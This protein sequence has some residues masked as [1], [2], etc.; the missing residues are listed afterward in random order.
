VSIVACIGR[1]D[2][3]PW[4]RSY[5]EGYGAWLAAEG[6]RMTSGN[7][8]GADQSFHL[9]FCEVDIHCERSELYLPWASFEERQLLPGQRCWL[10]SQALLGH[11]EAARA[12]HPIFDGLRPAVQ[13]LMIRNAMIV[14]RFDRPVDMVTAY[15]N[16]AKRGWGGTGHAIRVAGAA[17]VPVFL[18]NLQR[19]W[20][21]VEGTPQS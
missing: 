11:I 6:H 12:A 10:A 5:L 15:P 9:G 21:P 17:G 18:L 7:A 8:P 3:S 19:W 14:L 16:V 4:E 2:L 13:S 20:D 1:R